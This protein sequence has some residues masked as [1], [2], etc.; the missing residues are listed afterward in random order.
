M[1][2]DQLAVAKITK[3]VTT[4]FANDKGKSFFQPRAIV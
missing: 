4:V 1:N 3:A 2:E